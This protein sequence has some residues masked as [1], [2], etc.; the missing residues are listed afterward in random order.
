[1]GKGSG[2]PGGN[3]DFGTKYKFD[4]G[5]PEVRDQVIAIRFS[6]RELE[7]IKKGGGDSYRDFCRNAILE[8][9]RKALSE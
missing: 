2:R 3:P 7:E 1:M 8:A 6:A 4:F 9:T 5:N